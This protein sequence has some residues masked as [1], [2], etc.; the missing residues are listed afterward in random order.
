MMNKR[1]SLIIASLIFSLLVGVFSSNY[2]V[3]SYQTL[4]SGDQLLYS[5]EYYDEYIGDQSTLAED[6]QFN[7]S[8]DNWYYVYHDSGT[9]NELR[10]YVAG[11]VVGSI[12]YANYTRS[13]YGGYQEYES[14]DYKYNF[15]SGMW[16]EEYY[17]SSFYYDD[18]RDSSF[19]SS[20]YDVYSTVLNMDVT[21]DFDGTIYIGSE[22]ENVTINGVE[23]ELYLDKYGYSEVYSF[24]YGYSYYD[25]NYIHYEYDE[26]NYSFYIDNSTGTLI[27]YFIDRYNSYDHEFEGFSSIL[28]CVVSGYEHDEHFGKDTWLLK[29][30]SFAYNP[31]TDADIPALGVISYNALTDL[32]PDLT[33]NFY[34]SDFGNNIDFELFVDGVP[35]AYWNNYPSGTFSITIP[36]TYLEYWGPSYHAYL[37]LV[38][39]Y[40]SNNANHNSTWRF[41]V[42]DSRTRVPEWPCYIEGPTDIQVVEGEFYEWFEIYADTNW[43]LNVYKYD[44]DTYSWNY[45]E[46]WEDY[47]NNTYWLWDILTIGNYSYRL[48]LTDDGGNYFEHILNVGVIPGIPPGSPVIEGPKGDFYYSVGTPMTIYYQLFDDDPFNYEVFL[49]E[50]LIL[51]GNYNDGD[52][53]EIYLEDYIFGSAIYILEF[54]AYDFS[55]HETALY[56]KIH[57]EGEVVDT[58]DPEINGPDQPIYLKLHDPMKLKWEIYDDH[59]GYFSVKQNGTEIMNQI[60]H[61]PSEIVEIDLS[62]LGLGHYFFEIYIEDDYYNNAVETVEVYVTEEG[63][64]T[65]ETT[66]DTTTLGIDAPNILIITLGFVSLSVIPIMLRKR[67]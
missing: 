29:E 45:Y 33:I 66:D 40:D 67:R 4:T 49:N 22:F 54:Y 60:W 14:T 37:I 51:N 48:E 38:E 20:T 3:N 16:E 34:L 65:T 32:T 12:A 56:L 47:L 24:E 26:Y 18:Y 58:T 46:T 61:N 64:A 9:W 13:S 41:W 30:C 50:S 35:Y 10:S 57:A 27:Q 53:V 39:L 15:I 43:T 25:I 17:D 21:N 11:G 19:E 7:E 42:E 44:Y 28:G 36:E 31:V 52:W 5:V 2:A 55:G 59:P 6:A 63:T 8:L 1:G 23:Q 62:T